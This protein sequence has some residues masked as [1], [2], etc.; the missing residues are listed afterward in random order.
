M[1]KIIILVSLVAIFA[2][3]STVLSDI[4]R[5][6]EK[7]STIGETMI[8][9]EPLIAQ[10]KKGMITIKVTKDFSKIQTQRGSVRF[11][12]ESLDQLSEKFEIQSIAQRFRFNP[13]KMKAGLPDLSRIYTIRF[14]ENISPQR[15][16]RTFLQDPNIEYAEPIPKLY[17]LEAPNDP[18][19]PSQ[20]FL[21]QIKAEEAWEIHK[22]ENGED[23]VIIAIVDTGVDWD[24]AD[25]QSNAWQNLGEDADGDGQVMEYN[26]SEWTFD[27]DDENGIDDDGNGFI[28]DFTGWN[29]FKE[30]NDPTPEDYF[31][32]WEHGTHCAG[33]AAASTNNGAGIASITW[34]LSIMSINIYDP[35]SFELPWAYDGIIYAAENGADIIS[36]S[37]GDYY[38]SRA[39]LEVIEY[40]TGLGSIIVAAAAN[41]NQYRCPYP[42]SYPGVISVASVSKTDIKASY[43]NFGPYISI[44]APGGETGLNGMYSTLP[45]DTYGFLWGTSMAAPVL[46]GVLGLVRSYHPDWTNEAVIKQV[47]GTADDIGLLN[48]IYIHQLGSGRVNA[49]QA[50]SE[51]GVTLNQEIKLDIFDI[52]AKDIDNDGILAPGDT[53]TIDITLR[54]F[55]LGVT[56]PNAAFHISC[57]DPHI[58]VIQG[59]YNDTIPS[60][61][62]FTLS[63]A[64]QFIID[65]NATTHDVEF[66]LTNSSAFPI[67]Y[68]DTLNF[69]LLVAPDGI[70][71]YRGKGSGNA[72]SGEYIRNFL[73]DNGE[74]V[75]YTSTLPTEF[76]GFDAVFLSLG[77]LG[78]KWEDGTLVNDHLCE[79]IVSYLEYGGMLYFESGSFFAPLVY[80]ESPYLQ[81]LKELLCVAEIETPV[82]EN[83]IDSLYGMEGSIAE[84]LY[85][86][87]TYQNS[88]WYID[89][90]TPDENGIAMLEENDYGVVAVQGEG[91]Y[92]QKT[93][94]LNYAISKLMAGGVPGMTEEL[95]TNI[96][97]YLGIDIGSGITNPSSDHILQVQLFP[98]PVK[99][100]LTIKYTIQD[101]QEVEIAIY[102]LFGRIVL[103]PLSKECSPG[104]KT[105]NCDLDELEDGIYFCR[106]KVGDEEKT[107]KVIKF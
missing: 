103:T 91:E 62:Y 90:L 39:N 27:P 45:Y 46:A 3:S 94:M 89:I 58:A 56:D 38:F 22:G 65:E 53:V 6:S 40:A 107:I 5:K 25:L 67:V 61:N 20:H 54:N 99:Q 57:N 16:A 95:M 35:E 17:P 13:L 101:K 80:F 83:D 48:P 15:V 63:N 8:Y 102:D 64:F 4:N 23:E 87:S 50:L 92:G 86:T 69:E 36:N 26:G 29:Y 59:N 97:N 104:D 74:E 32:Y 76:K 85:F 18:H 31:L 41:N 9:A 52:Q 55:S 24:H 21:P 73:E 79:A 7:L 19:Y 88:F 1:R 78:Y 70:M 37:W 96:C 66:E 72:Y 77:N 84:G 14:P 105:L 28:D 42:A 93:I 82:F 12:I 34:N 10:V 44:S 30:T 81:E 75:H 47:I 43:S 68:G 106:V 60:D 33:L 71:V 100:Q 2:L 51:S 49:Y 11:N 98:N